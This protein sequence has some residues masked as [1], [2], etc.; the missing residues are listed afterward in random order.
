MLSP[1]DC[2]ISRFDAPARIIMP[3]RVF[4]ISRY[5]STASTMHT[6]DMNSRY[7]GY[8]SVSVSGIDQL[9]IAGTA[10]PCTSLPTMRLRS[11]S[12]TRIRP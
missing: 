8:E 3:M 6:A 12:N 5:S 4:A 10:T 2:T 7:T 11:S 1:S 9:K